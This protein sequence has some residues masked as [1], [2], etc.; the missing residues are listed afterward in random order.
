MFEP[1]SYPVAEIAI[2][3]DNRAQEF[4]QEGDIV[5]IRAPGIGIG[6]AEAK[7]WLWIL[8]DGFEL[9]KYDELINPVI[10]PFDA[11]GAYDPPAS[12]TKFDRRRYCVPLARLNQVLTIDLNRARD[13]ADEY[14]PFYSL[15]QDNHLWLTDRTP[16]AAEGLIFD[17]VLGDYI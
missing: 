15:D 8:I 11:T 4:T 3:L 9:Y 6:L 10:E 16:L 5:A 14:Q 13:T 12:Y 7:L 2:G 17:K 1:R